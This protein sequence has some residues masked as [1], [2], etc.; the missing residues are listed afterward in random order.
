MRYVDGQGNVYDQGCWLRMLSESR[1]F[2]VVGKNG[3]PLLQPG[4]SLGLDGLGTCVMD[5]S[6]TSFRVRSVTGNEAFNCDGNWSVLRKR[7]GN[8]TTIYEQDPSVW[9]LG[10]EDTIRQYYPNANGDEFWLFPTGSYDVSKSIVGN[11]GSPID[12]AT[13]SYQQIT[14]DGGKTSRALLVQGVKRFSVT[15]VLYSNSLMTQRALEHNFLWDWS[16]INS[17]DIF[18]AWYEG[19]ISGVAK[20]YPLNLKSV[21]DAPG[22]SSQ[23][24]GSVYVL[25]RRRVLD[26]AKNIAV[27]PPIFRVRDNDSMFGTSYSDSSTIKVET[28]YQ[29]ATT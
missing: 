28:V 24:Y 9:K 18:V 13:A 2:P 15:V 12:T 20:T 19:V 3:S 10:L 8:Y 1:I 4:E 23:R 29:F 7:S 22:S 25:T 16:G 6:A 11:G 27:F 21:I 14:G 5:N 17:R 26:S